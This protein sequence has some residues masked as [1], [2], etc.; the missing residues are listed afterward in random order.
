MSPEVNVA[1]AHAQRVVGQIRMMI[2]AGEQYWPPN[3]CL[4]LWA[5]DIE[6]LSNLLI[7]AYGRRV[8]TEFGLLDWESLCRGYLWH[9]KPF[10]A[11]QRWEIV[12]MLAPYL[13]SAEIAIFFNV[14]VDTIA[15]ERP[16]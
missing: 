15:R 2:G 16:Q 1:Q 12:Q 5:G 7:D 6:R 4:V 11:S 3:D 14:D 9:E 13:D 8:W 10:L